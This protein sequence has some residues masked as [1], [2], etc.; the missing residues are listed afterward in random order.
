M[1]HRGNISAGDYVSFYGKGNQ[2]HQLGTGYLVRHKIISPV[3][4]VEF[5]SER[6]S[7]IVLR[8]HWFSIIVLNA[9]A[10][11]EEKSDGSKDIFYEEFKQIFDHF[12]KYY[13][14]IPVGGFNAKSS[15]KNIFKT[16]LG[17]KVCIRVKD[18]G[19]RTLNFATSK[20]S[21]C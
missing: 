6:M 2:I 15:R 4:T 7:C 20:K 21:I 9:H 13:M 14:N 11:T 17:M 18:N 12:S 19:I 3:K 1:G 10:P 16:Q 5:V 8:G